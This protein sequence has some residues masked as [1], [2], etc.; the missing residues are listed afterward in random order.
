MK[1]K[2]E[3]WRFRHGSNRHWAPVSPRRR[4]HT[5]PRRHAMPRSCFTS[6]LVVGGCFSAAAALRRCASSAC[7]S[8]NSCLF[9][10]RRRCRSSSSSTPWIIC[11]DARGQPKAGKK[12]LKKECLMRPLLL[13]MNPRYNGRRK[14]DR[15]RQRRLG[16]RAHRF[17]VPAASEWS[18]FVE[19]T[20]EQCSTSSLHV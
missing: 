8:A 18:R 19:S 14:D 3:K 20:I 16:R 12:T 1:M 9:A 17:A 10:S 13:K 7:C 4:R 2:T 6:Q 5:R 15:A 11:F